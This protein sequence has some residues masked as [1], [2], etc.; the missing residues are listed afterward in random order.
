[1]Q[2]F[3]APFGLVFL[4]KILV[5]KLAAGSVEFCPGSGQNRANMGKIRQNRAKCG[6]NEKTS[7]NIYIA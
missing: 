3:T 4:K 1:M 2:K 5:S 7:Y 6:I